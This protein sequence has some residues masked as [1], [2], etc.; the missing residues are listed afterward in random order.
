VLTRSTA[1]F[2]AAHA[3]TAAAAQCAASGN[4]PA[5]QRWTDLATRA[6]LAAR[7]D[8]EAGR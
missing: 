7:L 8:A 5:A 6:T 4:T 3:A 2:R 1:G